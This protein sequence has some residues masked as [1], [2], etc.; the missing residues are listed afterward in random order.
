MR[1]AFN[2]SDASEEF[3]SLSVTRQ[4]LFLSLYAS[5]ITTLAR[6]YFVDGDAEMAQKCNESLHRILGYLSRLIRDQMPAPDKSFFEMLVQGAQQK[7][8]TDILARSLRESVGV[9]PRP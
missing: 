8:W 9:P 5:E 3:I 7:G 4:T 1:E 2:A 6:G